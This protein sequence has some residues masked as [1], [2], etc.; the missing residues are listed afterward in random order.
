MREKEQKT[1]ALS[2]WERTS[3][4]HFDTVVLGGGLVGL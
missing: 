2:Y 4:V 1:P 3:L